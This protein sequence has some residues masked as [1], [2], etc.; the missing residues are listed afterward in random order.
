MPLPGAGRVSD[1][2]VLAE[3]REHAWPELP[4]EEWKHTCRTLHMWQ[5]IVG[6]V[7]L[8]RTPWINHSWHVTL[9][10]TARGL[11][12]GA[13]PHG[14]RTFQLDF[15]F[16]EHRLEASTSVGVRRFMDLADRTVAD[17]YRDLMSALEDLDVGTRIAAKPNEVEDAIPFGEDRTHGSY[18]PEWANR[19]W[20]VLS[21]TARVFTEFRS[22]FKGKCSPVHH[23]WGGNDLAVTRFSGRT[24][25]PHP[26]GFPNLP[27]W[28]TREAYSH[29][30]SS[31]GFW[32]GSDD[33]GPIFYSYAYPT[34]DG[35]AEAEVRPEAAAWSNEL[36][37][38][39]LPY[40]A[41][42]RT[43]EPEAALMDFL[44]ST[45]EAAAELGG[46]S[47][48]ALEWGEGEQPDADQAV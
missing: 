45:W 25:P 42:R 39:V 18:D 5:Q 7:R 38:F 13:I 22:R 23:F 16:V 2:S 43:T 35:F 4:W 48:D 41:V 17:F 32:P 20:R 29:E 40:D 19:F 6:K 11:G 37:E 26:G 34:P 30:V 1:P 36:G 24:A 14:R 47:R 31:A 21:S 28:I 46:W 3:D 15:D 44:E 9:Y 8:A 27:D 10:P 12:T 33:S